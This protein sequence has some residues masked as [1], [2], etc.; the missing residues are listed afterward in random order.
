MPRPKSDRAMFT[1]RLEG[2]LRDRLEAVAARDSKRIG[3]AVPLATVLRGVIAI[4]LDARERESKGKV[5]R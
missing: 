4:G 5:R 1:I 2:D 3:Y